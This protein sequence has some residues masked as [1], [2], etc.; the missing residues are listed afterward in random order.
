MSSRKA[1]KKQN[2]SE[3]LLARERMALKRKH[4]RTVFLNDRELALLN[5][6]CRNNKVK[7]KSAL[8]RR[9]LIDR[10]LEEMGKNPP[11]LF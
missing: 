8:I 2:L 10:L 1:K 11:T 7:S 9:A 4:R 6:Y 5:E 3:S